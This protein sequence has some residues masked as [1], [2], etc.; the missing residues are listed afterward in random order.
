MI[1]EVITS[2]FKIHLFNISILK[3][4]FKNYYSQKS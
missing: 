1:E 3:P 2:Y 4:F